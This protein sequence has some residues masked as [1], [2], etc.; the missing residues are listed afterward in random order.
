[1]TCLKCNQPIPDGK[2]GCP[3]CAKAANEIA[4]RKFQ[5]DALLK[6]DAGKAEFTVYKMP[7][8]FHARMF[9]SPF[10]FCGLEVSG[11][12]KSRFWFGFDDVRLCEACRKAAKE[13]LAEAQAAETAAGEKS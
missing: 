6:I 13:I 12:P 4:M 11:G 7:S 9:G 3:A 1:M 10:S 5:H 2:V 8:G